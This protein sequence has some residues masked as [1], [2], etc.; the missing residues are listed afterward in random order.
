MAKRIIIGIDTRDLQIAKTG[1]RTYLEELCNQFKINDPRFQFYFLDTSIPVYTGKNKLLKLV[2]QLRFI[3]WKQIT[4]PIKAV[5]HRCD[6]VFC[7]DYFVPFLHLGF[8]TIPVFHD[9]FF[10][11]YPGHYNKYWLILF[12]ILG[13]GA[14]KRSPFI[15]TPSLYTRKRINCFS[16]IPIEK[17]VCIYEAP[18]S[19]PAKP[20]WAEQ[21]SILNLYPVLSQPFLLH[22][23]TF[24]KRKNLPVLIKAFAQLSRTDYPFFKLVLIGQV[25]PKKDMDDCGIIAELIKQNELEDRVILTGYVNDEVLRIFYQKA[26]LPNREIP[27]IVSLF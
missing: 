20:A 19:L 22:V 13:L 25:S 23:G 26:Y 2:E 10:W 21:R 6:I 8:I 9:A 15:I 7:T 5:Y 4:L 24:E 12:K 18:K 3:F 14:A 27:R 11:E 16:G 17:I 1:T